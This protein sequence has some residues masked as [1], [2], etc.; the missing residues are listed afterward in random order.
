MVVTAP[1]RAFKGLQHAALGP[2]IGVSLLV[3]V[4]L[5]MISI[6]LIFSSKG[7][8]QEINNQ[9]VEMLEKRL[10][11]PDINEA[12]KAQIEDGIESVKSHGPIIMFTALALGGAIRAPILLLLLAS[13]LFVIAKILET[14]R[15][16]RITF[17][18]ALA[19]ASLS[20]IVTALAGVVF[21]LIALAVGNIELAEG[22]GGLVHTDSAALGALIGA[23]SP[24]YLWWYIVV[25]IGIATIAKSTVM[26]STIS[27]ASVMIVCFVLL[28]IVGS[29]ISG[30]F[31]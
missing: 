24:A 19:V 31:G 1:R 27:F 28:G 17:G 6:A 9:Q 13:A 29:M 16:T 3:A 25:G 10:D 12:Q 15:E 22:I 5:V 21:A 2:I 30:I 7:F 20:S 11:S 23:L 8:V 26:K 18:Q 14:G 4:V